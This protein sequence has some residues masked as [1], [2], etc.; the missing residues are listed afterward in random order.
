MRGTSN[1]RLVQ[2]SPVSDVCCTLFLLQAMLPEALSPRL[3]A[4]LRRC[5]QA[6][7][8]YHK[9]NDTAVE[10]MKAVRVRPSNL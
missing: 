4:W 8:G 3:V 7:P 9:V 2:L 5:E 6:L 10:M 1:C